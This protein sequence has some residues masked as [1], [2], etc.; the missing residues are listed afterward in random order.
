M[1][2]TCEQMQRL[3]ESAFL[4]GVLAKD[5]MEEAGVGIAKV[6]QQFFPQTGALVLCLGKGNNAGD[7]LV[8]ARI[9]KERGWQI[10]VRLAYA[11]KDFKALPAA[12][13]KALGGE[14]KIVNSLVELSDERGSVVVMDGL[15]GIGGVGRGALRGG[16]ADVVLEINAL[17]ERRHVEVMAL[18]LP[19]GLDGNTGVPGAC[20]VRADLTITIACVKVGLLA[21]AA[22]N[23]V[24]R[25]VVV[26]LREL[27]DGAGDA[28][29]VVL[30]SNRLLS[31][32]PR[33]DFD[34]HKGRAGRVGIV[35]GSRGMLGAAVL[36]ARGA[37]HGGAGLVTVYVRE[38]MYALLA[39]MMP[40]EVMVKPVPNYEVCLEDRLD[41]LV[42]GPGLGR[43]FAE[44]V[45]AILKKVAVPV[46]LDADGI[47]AMAESDARLDF[48]G[49]VK[50]RVLLTPH[51]GEMARLV[52]GAEEWK[53]L[54]RAELARE[55]AERFPNVQLLLKGS[56]TVIAAKGRALAFNTTGN[57][58]MASGGM[59]DVLSGL[60]GALIAQGLDGY[61]AACLGAW[62]SGRSAELAITHGEVSQES[63]TAGDVAANLGRAFASLKALDF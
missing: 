4:R 25:L 22:V 54:S 38:E 51:P 20:C 39:P 42:I 44:E 52:T 50:A 19:S 13:W 23:H 26:P 6:V 47:N 9:L 55:F 59:G 27:A 16:L 31:K 24:G 41:V 17:R 49:E 57:P 56:R 46:V 37:L 36:S 35:A 3:E 29:A 53:C 10:V 30:L 61:D 48:L 32:L 34:F 15:I 63:L 1:M 5:L 62:L 11:E 60:C 43:M 14:F 18:D 28:D 12:H 45:R 33:R 21:D 7:A 2:V 8:A 58:G 40:V